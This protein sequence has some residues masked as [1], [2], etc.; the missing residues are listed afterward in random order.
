MTIA[1]DADWRRRTELSDMLRTCRY[2]YHRPAGPR[3]DRPMRQK[4]VADLAG[5][6]MRRYAA[7]ERGQVNPSPG[8]VES[9]AAALRMTEAERSTLHV[10]ATGQDPPRA[11][12]SASDGDVPAVGPDLREFIARQA[13]DP[14]VITDETWTVL[15]GNAALNDWTGGWFERVP[16]SERNMMLWLFSADASQVL[17]DVHPVRRASLAALR[18]RYARNIASPRFIALVN[19]ILGTGD[20]AR[21][22]WQHHELMIPRTRHRVTVR[23]PDRGL[24]NA[25]GLL[26]PVSPGLWLDV[27]MFPSGIDPNRN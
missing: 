23:H 26:L 25:T 13:P 4:D 18:Y 22:L 20:E 12:L 10:L 27:I 21:T 11:A 19:R 5:L 17:T 6:S 8:L 2:R 7:F 3:G 9:V 16:P 14:A 24:I 1:D 15:A